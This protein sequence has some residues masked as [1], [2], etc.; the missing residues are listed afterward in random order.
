MVGL[1]SLLFYFFFFQAEDGIRDR[2]VTGVQTCALPIS[3]RRLKAS[4]R[5]G[6]VAKDC[7][8]N[9]T[10][11]PNFSIT[12]SFLAETQS[13]ENKARGCNFN[14]GSLLKQCSSTISAKT[15]RGLLAAHECSAIPA[16]RPGRLPWGLHGVESRFRRRGR[17]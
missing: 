5:K 14:G 10:P 11:T 7:R 17:H 15:N 1:S 16:G 3:S 8:P 6:R 2:T 4:R 13:V 9:T 12:G